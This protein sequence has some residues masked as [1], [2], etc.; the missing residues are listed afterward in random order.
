MYYGLERG[1]SRVLCQNAAFR[2]HGTVSLDVNIDGLPIFK[3]SKLQFWPLLVKFNN[4][5]PLIVALYCGESKP[6]P[7]DHYLRHFWR[8]NL[9]QNGRVYHDKKVRSKYPH[10][11]TKYSQEYGSI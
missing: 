5:S 2:Q 7:L 10:F 9:Q 4:F 3:S 1:I 11:V 8:M 6:E